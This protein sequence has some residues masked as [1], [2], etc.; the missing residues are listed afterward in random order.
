VPFRLR[1]SLE[2]KT[3]LLSLQDNATFETKLKR[4][5]VCLK[6]LEQDPRQAS[7]HAHKYRSLSGPNGEEVWEVYVENNTP[8][9]WRVW[10]WYGP[11]RHDISIL[12]IGPHL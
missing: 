3:V 4:V 9:A 10:Y 8:S 1:F 2:A 5:R 12:A 11:D 7:L 6:R